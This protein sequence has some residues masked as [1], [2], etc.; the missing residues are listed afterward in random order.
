LQM[1]FLMM[2]SRQKSPELEI[3]IKSVVKKLDEDSTHSG[4]WK[5][6]VR[7]IQAAES[8]DFPKAI[9]HANQAIAEAASPDSFEFV[10]ECKRAIK[11]FQIGKPHRIGPE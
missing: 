10:S 3:A 1:A 2:T 6:L 4:C 11:S 7:S 8:G 5:S 9:E